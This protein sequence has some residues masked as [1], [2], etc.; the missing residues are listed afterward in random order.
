MRGE[1]LRVLIAEDDAV[2]RTLLQKT[3]AK[4][5]HDPIV[6]CDGREALSILEG[7]DA[8]EIAILDWM[9]PEIDGPEICR[10]TRMRIPVT[11]V[12]IILLTAKSQRDDLVA[13][14]AAGADDYVTKPFDNQELRAKFEVGVRVVNLQR[15]LS[16]RAHDLEVALNELCRLQQ[17]QKL[18]AL[19]QMASGIAHEINTPLQYLGDNIRFIRESWMQ[20]DPFLRQAADSPE[21][22]YLVREVPK[23]INE[24]LQGTEKITRIVRAIRNFSRRSEAAK[25]VIDLNEAL[26]TTLIVSTSEWKYVADVQTNF[27]AQLP[28]VL[29]LPREIYQ[30]LLSLVVNA[31]HA[32]TDVT[33]GTGKKGVL[34]LTT[35]SSG[36]CVEVRISDTGTGIRAE[37]HQKIFEPFFTTKDIGRGAGQSLAT[38]YSIVT[39]QHNG[40]IWFESESGMGTTFIIRLPID[41]I[42]EKLDE[43]EQANSVR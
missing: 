38:A 22:D 15:Q 42:G 33:A 26:E 4:W 27:D 28:R 2:S 11:S 37:H 40:R 24:C 14:L 18:E 3:L 5:G 39:R 34:R 25:V 16:A 35:S 19:G 21:M 8:P 43:R 17:G 30:V 32:I 7:R 20:V 36:G 13:G 6:A 29:C 31:A 10:R 1:R 9:M 23:A 12:Y 41:G